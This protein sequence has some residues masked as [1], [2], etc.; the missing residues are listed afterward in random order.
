MQEEYLT[1]CYWRS[2]QP[3]TDIMD[4]YDP[5]KPYYEQYKLDF[6]QFKSLFVALSPW[7]SGQHV[8]T[9]ALRMFRVC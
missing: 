7:S 2:N 4:K 9:L 3:P 1:V 5:G 6:D 8:D